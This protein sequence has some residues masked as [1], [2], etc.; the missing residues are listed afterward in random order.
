MM[1]WLGAP[2]AGRTKRGA[3]RLKGSS[4]YRSQS[5]SGSMVWRSL[6][7]TRNPFFMARSFA[8]PST[9]GGGSARFGDR[10]RRAEGDEQAQDAEQKEVDGGTPHCRHEIARRREIGKE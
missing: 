5:P 2:S 9:D 4:R 3:Y 10:R 7:R 6:S 1:G 8:A